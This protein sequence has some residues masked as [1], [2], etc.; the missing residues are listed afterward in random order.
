MEKL[1]V[2]LCGSF[3]HSP[4]ELA[5]VYASLTQRYT[6]LSPQSLEF[7]DAAAE[8]VRLPHE[9]E[10][11]VHQVEQ[12]HLDAIARADFVWLFAPQGYVGRSAAMEIGWSEALGV[13]V[14]CDE[15]L[16]DEML[17]SFVT[18]VESLETVPSLV[19]ARPGRGLVGLQEYYRRISSRRDWDGE[20]DQDRLLAIVEELGELSRAV[21][22]RRGGRRDQAWSD[23]KVEHE[24]AD[25]QLYLVHLANLLEVDVASAVTEKDA[26]NYQRFMDSA[27]DE[28]KE[29]TVREL[30]FVD[31]EVPDEFFE[32]LS[33]YTD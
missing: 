13:P 9:L 28:T 25:V 14:Y 21:R 15:T 12:Q 10:A 33:K 4:E 29:N 23:K 8:F 19:A 5:R 22:K 24:V 1:S 30:G 27:V 18:Q 17:Q 6:V 20:T 2:V 7:V 31:Y 11:P 16:D 32:P 26:I 3:R